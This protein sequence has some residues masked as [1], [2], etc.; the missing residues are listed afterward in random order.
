MWKIWPCAARTVISQHHPLFVYFGPSSCMSVKL[1]NAF[2]WVE[3]NLEWFRK[4]CC[5]SVAHSCLTLCHPMDCST[6][7][8]PVLHRLP[9]FA[10]IHVPWISD[11]VQPSQPLLPSSPFASSL[12]QHQVLFK[13]VSSSYQ[14]TRVHPMN[15]QDWFCLGLTGLIS[16]QSKR[17][18]GVFSNTT[19]QKHQFFGA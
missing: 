18:S 19:V 17:L 4:F 15:I 8:S 7:G 16:F 1:N 5:C 2:N 12:S 3:G 6:R 14:M 9:E 11:A 10:Q 13:W